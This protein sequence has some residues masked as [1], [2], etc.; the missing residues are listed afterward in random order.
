MHF[1]TYYYTSL[2]VDELGSSLHLLKDNPRQ[3]LLSRI[4]PRRLI[5]RNIMNLGA[6]TDDL[7]L[8]FWGWVFLWCKNGKYYICEG[9]VN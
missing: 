1:S 7:S 8:K 9:R 5:K 2:K 6:R 3:G 4:V